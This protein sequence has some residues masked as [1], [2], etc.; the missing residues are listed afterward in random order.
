M[1]SIRD[2]SVVRSSTRPSAKYCCSGSSPILVNGSTT[3]GLAEG[4]L[5]TTDN[6]SD[7]GRIVTVD[8]TTG[9]VVP[10]IT[11]LP[12]GPTGQLAFQDGWI[13][14]SAGA[15]TNSGVLNKSDGGPFGQPDIPCQ[16]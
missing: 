8:P 11:G 1:P 5:F 12:A 2:R 14:W 6:A 4:R 16:D 13:Y 3:T 15:T 9:K 10:L 7:G